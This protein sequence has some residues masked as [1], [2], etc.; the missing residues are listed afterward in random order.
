MQSSPP[1]E[2]LAGLGDFAKK[3]LSQAQR[4]LNEVRMLIKQ[5]AG[6]VERLTQRSNQAVARQKEVEASLENFS[7][8]EIRQTFLAASESQLRL[9]MMQSQLEQLQSRQRSLDKFIDSLQRTVEVSTSLSALPGADRVVIEAAPLSSPVSSPSLERG[10]LTNGQALARIIEAQED[11]RNRVA[12]QIH[13]GPAQALTN[14]VLRAE[15]CERLMGIDPVR[16][17]AE[18]GQLKDLVTSTLRDTRR[19]IFDVRPMILDDLGLFPTLKKYVESIG[20]KSRFEVDLAVRGEERRLQP[21]VEVVLFRIVQEALQNVARHADASVARV[22]VDTE[23]GV[24]RVTIEDDGVGFDVGEV[25][26]NASQ[27]R[28]VSFGLMSM[29]ERA[30]TVGGQVDFESEPGRGTKVVASIPLES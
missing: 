28:G 25:L 2:L 5:T 12:R 21:H 1:S 20:E 29:M 6:E 18:L 10:A 26:A 8:E 3:E 13:D 7:R 14:V 11:E 23:G 30:E 19:F 22:V 16:A 24:C 15:I 9:F 27:R 17:R 4:D